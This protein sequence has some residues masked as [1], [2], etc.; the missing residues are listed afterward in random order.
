MKFSH[1]NR[2]IFSGVP[3]NAAF[4]F[5]PRTWEQKTALKKMGVWWV[6]NITVSSQTQDPRKETRSAKQV[7]EC[8][9]KKWGK[10]KGERE[11]RKRG[12]TDIE[13]SHWNPWSYYTF[14]HNSFQYSFNQLRYFNRINS[15][16]FFSHTQY[17][18]GLSFMQE[19]IFMVYLKKILDGSQNSALLFP[20]RGIVSLV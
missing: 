15:I 20:V 12:H 16:V 8:S 4:I 17:S 10:R 19:I 7:R 11:R 3:H 14:S 6:Y 9:L 1:S 5:P 2:I 13:V 18:S